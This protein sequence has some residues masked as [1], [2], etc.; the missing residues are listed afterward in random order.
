MNVVVWVVEGTWHSCIDAAEE[1]A[2]ADADIALLYVVDEEVSRVVHGAFAGLIGRGGHRDR[3]DP[4]VQADAITAEAG[5]ELLAAAAERLARRCT[6]Q[7]RHGRIE[8]EVVEA[9]AGADLLVVARDGDRRRLGPKSLGRA[10]RFVVDH[11]PCRVLLVWPGASPD[12]ATIPPP[13]QGHHPPGHQPPGHHLPPGP[14]PPP[15]R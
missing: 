7:L 12:I 6:S 5:R 2:P 15:H 9:S 13:P 14:P 8:R 3:R 1:M 11:A 4:G 10:S